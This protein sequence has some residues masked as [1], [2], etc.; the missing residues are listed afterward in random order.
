MREFFDYDPLT[1]VTEYYEEADGKITIHSEQDVEPILN[2]AKALANEGL[3]DENWKKHGISVYAILPAVALS[4][5]AK[6]GIRY[7]DPNHIGAVVDEVNRNFEYCK[8]TYKHHA[9]K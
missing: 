2:Y 5:M 3:P 8:T 9:V 4:H 1:G 6:K 7:L